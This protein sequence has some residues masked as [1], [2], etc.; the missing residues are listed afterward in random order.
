VAP[1]YF[2]AMRVRV[3]CHPGCV[4]WLLTLALTL[5]YGPA[6]LPACIDMSLGAAAG[7]GCIV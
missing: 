4:L 2:F 1:C 7:C 6:R 3:R 5:G